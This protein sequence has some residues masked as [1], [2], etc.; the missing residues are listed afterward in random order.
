MELLA[1]E[2]SFQDFIFGIAHV[3]LDFAV[4]PHTLWVLV[5]D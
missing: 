3:F 4:V 2:L 1:E 5:E